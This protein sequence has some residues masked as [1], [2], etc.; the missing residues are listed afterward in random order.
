MNL[1]TGKG[2]NFVFYVNPIKDTRLSFKT[3]TILFFNFINTIDK[4]I[5]FINCDKYNLFYRGF[6]NKILLELNFY[7]KKLFHIESPQESYIKAVQSFGHRG[8]VASFNYQKN[9]LPKD[10]LIV[11]IKYYK[12]YNLA[13]I[14]K[15]KI[16]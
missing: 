9:T 12:Y 13:K 7:L 16:I 11:R 10:I 8:I 2:I 14:M 4:L 3:R 1:R 5:H 15:I 6:D